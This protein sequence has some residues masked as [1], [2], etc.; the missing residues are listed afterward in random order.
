[1]VTDTPFSG[2]H[3]NYLSEFPVIF[4]QRAGSCRLPLAEPPGTGASLH[5]APS[6]RASQ[7][8]SQRSLITHICPISEHLLPSLKVPDRR[9]LLQAPKKEE[10]LQKKMLVSRVFSSYTLGVTSSEATPRF[11]P[12][13]SHREGHST[14]RDPLVHIL[15]S[16]VDGEVTGCKN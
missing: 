1:M 14:T 5:R 6:E 8:P 12:Q 10:P 2:P 3:Y 15:K 13:S 4:H 9:D 16:P 7:R 11:P